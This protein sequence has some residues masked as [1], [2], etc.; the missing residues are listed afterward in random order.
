MPG[1]CANEYASFLDAEAYSADEHLALC[2]RLRETI[3]LNCG[4]HL[5]WDER[6]QWYAGT[7]RS[8]ARR[9]ASRAGGRD[10]L[11]VEIFDSVVI[12][13]WHCRPPA[14][15]GPR[16]RDDIGE[17]RPALESE[18]MLAVYSKEKPG[19]LIARALSPISRGALAGSRFSPG[20]R[21]NRAQFADG[22]HSLAAQCDRIR[23]I[24]IGAVTDAQR[25]AI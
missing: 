1:G 22:L 4:N 9:A 18:G 5:N 25:G 15:S 16:I 12:S 2:T 19:A 7:D 21:S 23:T 11:I 17:G 14:A 10:P 6:P 3:K 20:V 8:R 13:V 24:R